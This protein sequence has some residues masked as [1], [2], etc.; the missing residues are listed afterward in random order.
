[1]TGVPNLCSHIRGLYPCERT[2]SYGV[3]E[4]LYTEKVLYTK[5][6]SNYKNFVNFSGLLV[7][8]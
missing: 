2:N 4:E 3:A 1:M 7:R 8:I 5:I 6:S